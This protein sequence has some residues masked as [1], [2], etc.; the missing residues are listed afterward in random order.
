MGGCRWQRASGS[1][2]VDV[3]AAAPDFAP[4]QASVPQHRPPSHPCRRHPPPTTAH[5]PHLLCLRRPFPRGTEKHATATHLPARPLPAFSPPS[6]II[7]ATKDAA[8]SSS[9]SSS[10]SPFVT[11]SRRYAVPSSVPARK[12][13][14]RRPGVLPNLR[15]ATNTTLIGPQL[16]AT[17]DPFRWPR[18]HSNLPE[19]C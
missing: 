5:R 18:A 7:T 1:C 11:R 6:A 9:F 12:R 4:R 16:T 3:G 10:L 2:G 8:H 13:L 15:P 19:N 17:N 14:A